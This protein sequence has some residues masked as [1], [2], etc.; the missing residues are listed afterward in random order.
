M[1]LAN[2]LFSFS[3]HESS[4]AKTSINLTVLVFEVILNVFTADYEK[5]ERNKR[6]GKIKTLSGLECTFKVIKNKGK[7]FLMLHEV[8]V[9]KLLLLLCFGDHNF[10]RKSRG[11]TFYSNIS[12]IGFFYI[13]SKYIQFVTQIF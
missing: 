12:Y 10:R 11:R 5:K 6:E 13:Y 1:F 9:V 3:R 2:F 4:P 7:I 8:N